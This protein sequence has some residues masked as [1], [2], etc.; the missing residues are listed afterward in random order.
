MQADDRALEARGRDHVLPQRRDR[1]DDDLRFARAQA[2]QERHPRAALRG[3]F[4]RADGLVARSQERHLAVAAQEV[5]QVGERPLRQVA[6]RD[7]GQDRAPQRPVDTRQQR[8]PRAG[9]RLV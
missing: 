1:R 7:H 3:R 5:G 8:G 6:G 9:G 2:G 4:E